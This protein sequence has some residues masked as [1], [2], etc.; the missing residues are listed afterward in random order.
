MCVGMVWNGIL[1]GRNGVCA[2]MVRGGICEL[3][4][5]SRG[6][7]GKERGRCFTTSTS[8]DWNAKPTSAFSSA[9]ISLRSISSRGT[10]TERGEADIGTQLHA[11]TVRGRSEG[12]AAEEGVE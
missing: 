11:A 5:V 3:G 4:G 6:A 12:N 9:N 2:G 7:R 1:D 8:T 10:C